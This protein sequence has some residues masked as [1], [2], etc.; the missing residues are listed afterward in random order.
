MRSGH[1]DQ[2]R[3]PPRRGGWELFA[4]GSDI[5]VRGIA[6]TRDAAFECAAL[7]LTGAI[8]DPGTVARDETVEI[9]CEAAADDLLLYAW[10]NAVVFEMATRGMLFG[11]YDVRIEGLRL[12]GV[13]RGEKVDV[14]RHRPAVEVKGA[15][16][17]E[18]DVAR[19]PNGRWRAQCVVDV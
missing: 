17:T 3:A 4:H 11:S 7:A 6:D 15:T 10:L 5:G 12:T 9:R 1:V 16:M 19:D 14:A 8:T 18:L 13:C 2:N